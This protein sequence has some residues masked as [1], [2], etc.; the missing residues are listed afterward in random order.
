MNLRLSA[1]FLAAFAA[2]RYLL[3]EL[4]EFAHMGMARALCGTWG[5]RDF[6]NVH[7]IAE[8]CVKTAATDPLVS[9]AGPAT[10][11]LTLWLAALLLLPRG[12]G[13]AHPAQRAPDRLAW[14]L[15]LAFAALPL[16][17]LFTAVMGGG[18][19]LGLARSLMDTPWTA[20][21][22]TVLMITGVMAWPLWQVF[23]ALR[24]AGRGWGFFVLA[25]LL[26]MLVEGA[27]VQGLLNR[28]LLQGQLGSLEGLA[29]GAPAAVLALLL[30]AGL[31]FALL[32][33]RV[34]D[35]CRPP[36]TSS[37]SHP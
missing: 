36:G 7:P 29:W 15:A 10:N 34:A 14:G 2:L 30:A 6:N 37:T 19:E 23:K 28:L 11:Y 33:R 13:P 3:H 26:P 20:R 25:L 22:L 12:Q 4:H 24:S 21:V 9:L 17:R 1:A 27:L 8:T 16:A 35:V 5:T 31:A 18:D 32:A